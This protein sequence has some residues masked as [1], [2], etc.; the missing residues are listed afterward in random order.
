MTPLYEY[1]DKSQL[2]FKQECGDYRLYAEDNAELASICQGFKIG[3]R[4]RKNQPWM[5]T[6]TLLDPNQEHHMER[7]IEEAWRMMHCTL[8]CWC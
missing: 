2:Q 4:N 3:T 5:F 7:A 8:S 6:C 1:N